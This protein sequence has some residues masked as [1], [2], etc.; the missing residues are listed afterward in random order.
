MK[1]LIFTGGLGNQIFGY[2]FYLW[3]KKTFP[4]ERVY[5]FYSDKKMGEHYGLEIDKYFNVNLP[6]SPYWVRIL[7]GL[8]YLGKKIGLTTH[9][10]D[11]QVR[12]FKYFTKH[13]YR[14]FSHVVYCKSCFFRNRKGAF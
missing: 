2:A 10:V 14:R 5:G 13:I 3:L 11:M 8:L 9:L 1:V 7:T 12:T 6:S 4:K